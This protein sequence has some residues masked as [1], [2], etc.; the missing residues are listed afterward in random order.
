MNELRLALNERMNENG[1]SCERR[2]GGDRN[3][4]DASTDR[5]G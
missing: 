3:T 4:H 2:C 1:G 5:D